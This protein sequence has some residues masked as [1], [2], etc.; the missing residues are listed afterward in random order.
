MLG[1]DYSAATH[2]CRCDTL[3]PGPSC[4][5]SIWKPVGRSPA[6][7]KRQNWRWLVAANRP[8][9]VVDCSSSLA[10]LTQV[11]WVDVKVACRIDVDFPP[12][13]YCLRALPV[14]PCVSVPCR[15]AWAAVGALQELTA[16]WCRVECVSPIFSA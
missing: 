12:V 6:G 16:T 2:N 3:P 8:C 5:Q 4:P 10:G 11:D 13:T 15:G 9:R 1:V 7:S 14:T